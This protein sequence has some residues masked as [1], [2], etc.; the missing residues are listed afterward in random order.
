M[1][2]INEKKNEHNVKRVL[3]KQIGI[4]CDLHAHTLLT[5]LSQLEVM[6]FQ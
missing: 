6:H 1:K 2:K 5:F 4:E 3:E